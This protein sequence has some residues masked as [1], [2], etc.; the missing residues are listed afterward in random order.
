[1]KRHVIILFLLL[2]S[3][4]CMAQSGTR[5]Q[6][7]VILEYGYG[8]RWNTYYSLGNEGFIKAEYALCDT[9]CIDGT[10]YREVAFNDSSDTLYY[11]QDGQK[12]FCFKGGE[13]HLILDFGLKEGDVFTDSQGK[14]FRVTSIGF[15]D[16]FIF[17]PR[18]WYHNY[19][20][21]L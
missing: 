21:I 2:L 15:Y 16:D 9:A 1:M 17:P 14:R 19:A 13:E 3:I 8:M 4:G 11:R 10:T 18:Q 12:V 7:P 20:V 5:L 6:V